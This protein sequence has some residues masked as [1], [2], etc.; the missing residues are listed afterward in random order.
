MR[1][2]QDGSCSH[3]DALQRVSMPHN[4]YEAGHAGSDAHMRLQPLGMVMRGHFGHAKQGECGYFEA[5]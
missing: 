3:Q 2:H 5:F 1:S 4:T